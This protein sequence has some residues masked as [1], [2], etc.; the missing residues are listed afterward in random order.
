MLRCH[1][2]RQNF[3]V[4]QSPRN[5]AVVTRII[6]NAISIFFVLLMIKVTPSYQLGATV[7]QFNL[8]A[9]TNLS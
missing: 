1:S 7:F 2:G 3:N 4:A 9:N 6:N 5:I 8:T